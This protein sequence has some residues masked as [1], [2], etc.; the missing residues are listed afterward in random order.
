MSGIVIQNFLVLEKPKKKL[1]K[2]K[3]TLVVYVFNSV[4]PKYCFNIQPIQKLLLS[5]LKFKNILFLEFVVSFYTCSTS[6]RDPAHFR[7]LGYTPAVAAVLSHMF[8][9]FKI[10]PVIITVTICNFS[11]LFCFA[12]DSSMHPANLPAHVSFARHFHAVRKQ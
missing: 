10:I 1:S 3:R 4:Y 9:A 2:P 11:G 7:L 12:S 6:Q 8:R 5:Y